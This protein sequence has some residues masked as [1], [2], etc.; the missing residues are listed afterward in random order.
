MAWDWDK[1]QQQRGRHSGTP[2]QMDDI[3]EKIK[4]L[5]GRFQ[6]W[7]II[8]I[9]LVFII[10]FT[11]VYTVAVDEVGVIQFFG[12]YSRTTS[13]GLHFKL[14]SG[15]EK[16]TKVP[17]RSVQKEE[18]GF[19]TAEAGIKTKYTSESGSLG[20]SLMLTGDLN[21]AVVPW[22][23]QYRI[24]DPYKYLFKVKDIKGTLRDLSEAA[25]RLV[26]GDRSINEVIN[27]RAE[28][29]NEA[30]EQLQK[31]LDEA[32]TGINL[33]TIEMKTTTVPEPVQPSWNEVNQAGQ[34]KEKMI[35]QAQ[36][37]YNKLIPQAKGQAE[38]TIKE[39]EGYALDRVNR[40]KG[41]ASRYL[42]LYEEY[43]KAKDVTRRRLYLEALSD[44]FP[45]LGNKYIVDDKQKNLLPLLNLGQ[46]P[47]TGGEK[48]NPG[49]S[50]YR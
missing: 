22:I 19:K 6:G 27:K 4:G 15:I 41:D 8:I 3:L 34:E 21:V 39:A 36:E 48:C 20:E 49:Q 12:K 33:V 9:I 43:S 31:E 37:E 29:A 47:A 46:Q 13:P 17:V 1:L 35:Y 16:L 50:L 40:A 38:G 32:E 28:I 11:M 7:W 24:D 44:V 10:G 14:P 2:P 23:V 45:K 42:A 25:M 5:K 18:F 30:K 26:V